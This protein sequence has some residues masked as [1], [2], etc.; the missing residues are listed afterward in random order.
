MYNDDNSELDDGAPEQTVVTTVGTA[1]E[2]KPCVQMLK[3]RHVFGDLVTA[4]EVVTR[5]TIASVIINYESTRALCVTQKDD[6]EYWI[7]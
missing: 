6:N 2:M 4:A 7:Q 5:Y 3:H 1:S